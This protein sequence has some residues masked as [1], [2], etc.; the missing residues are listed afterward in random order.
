M[1]SFPQGNEQETSWS[2]TA[3][4]Q[5]QAEVVSK[6]IV[7]SSMN[8]NRKHQEPAANDRDFVCDFCRNRIPFSHQPNIMA[9]VADFENHCLT[10]CLWPANI[11]E[12][13]TLLGLFPASHHKCLVDCYKKW[14]EI[15]QREQHLT[16]VMTRMREEMI[17]EGVS[18]D[19][20]PPFLRG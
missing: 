20:L 19:K 4:D 17:R 7:G 2:E 12:G 8:K 10:L 18:P 15:D 5:S 11:A 14:Q 1:E 9:A 6:A 16:M 13:L 3:S